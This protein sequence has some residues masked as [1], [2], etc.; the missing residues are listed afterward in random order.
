MNKVNP[1]EL[2]EYVKKA[3]KGD[4]KSFEKIYDIY[5]VKILKFVSYKVQ[6]RTEAEDISSEIWLQVIKSLKSYNFKSTF[7]TWLYGLAK[8]IIYQYYR[9][10]Y[11][12]KELVTFDEYFEQHNVK[13]EDFDNFEKDRLA[14]ESN[15]AETY[16]SKIFGSLNI[17]QRKVLDLRYLKG[18]KI[19]EVAKEMQISE[20]NV[21]VTQMRAINKLKKLNPKYDKSKK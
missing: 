10:K 6:S 18:Y 20:S 19:S 15:E 1:Q 5:A 13:D 9:E 3:Q 8:N 4:K 12:N 21:K 2:V 14:V 16:L 11:S 7:N 17:L